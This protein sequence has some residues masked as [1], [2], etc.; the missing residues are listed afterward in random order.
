MEA[1]LVNYISMLI[2]AKRVMEFAS[3]HV[4]LSNAAHAVGGFGF[5]LLL[6]YYLTGSA[7]VPVWVGWALLA[8]AVAWHLWVW[9]AAIMK[10]DG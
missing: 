4:V 1:L 5:A 10:H 6:Q 9:W 8:C 2:S 3:R 7:F